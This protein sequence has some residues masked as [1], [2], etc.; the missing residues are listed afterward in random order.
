MNFTF[1]H[2]ADIHLGS[3]MSGLALKDGAV[4]EK[5][6]AACRESFA[7]LVTRAI[8]AKVAFV[9]IAGDLYDGDWQ[10]NGIGLFFN[11]Q[12]ARLARALPHSTRLP[13]A[14]PAHAAAAAAAQH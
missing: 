5:F 6:A 1:L 12:A 14:A 13:I 9:L 4:A 10:D 2:C 8:E 11:R 3:P 7:D